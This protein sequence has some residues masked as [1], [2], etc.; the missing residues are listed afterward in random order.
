MTQKE[1]TEAEKIEISE[2][3]EQWK[4]DHPALRWDADFS[5]PDWQNGALY[6]NLKELTPRKWAWEFRRR[7]PYYRMDWFERNPRAPFDPTKAD[8]D[9][10][11][12]VAENYPR[13]HTGPIELSLSASDAVIVIDRNRP[14][15]PQ[16]AAV[17]RR[18]L[19]R[20]AKRYETRLR[21]NEYPLYLRV[22]DAR[23]TG[24]KPHE[25]AKV[26]GK[27]RVQIINYLRAADHLTWHG[28]FFI[29]RKQAGRPTRK[30][31]KR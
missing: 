11:F 14:L 4:Q 6:P 30:N 16:L 17:K 26:L 24:A 22:L 3:I 27:T 31:P 21:S 12:E 8:V 5:L 18:N 23:S 25:I 20:R 19:P 9:P 15:A 13:I 29:A 10:A 1:L 7:N 28:Y 2:T